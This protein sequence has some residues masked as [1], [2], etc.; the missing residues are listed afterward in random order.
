MRLY[1]TLQNISELEI[2]GKAQRESARRPKSDWRKYSG[3]K[4]SPAAVTWRELKCISIL[5]RRTHTVDL[6]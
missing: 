2:W 6:V 4:I 1:T 3:S 5:V